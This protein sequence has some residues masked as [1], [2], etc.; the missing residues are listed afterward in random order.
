MKV[1]RACNNYVAQGF[2]IRQSPIAYSEVNRKSE[3]TIWVSTGPCS[4]TTYITVLN[5]IGQ[6]VTSATGQLQSA[7]LSVRTVLQYSDTIVQN[8]VMGQSPVGGNFGN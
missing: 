6:N 8:T 1:E 7:G 5:V 4:G 2:V 3:I